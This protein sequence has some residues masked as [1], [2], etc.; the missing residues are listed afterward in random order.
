MIVERSHPA[1]AI[2]AP[3]APAMQINR[4]LRLAIAAVL[5]G[6]LLPGE[7]SALTLEQRGRA[8]V[9]KMC[10]ACHAVGRIGVSPH[11]GAPAFRVLDRRFDL[12]DFIVRLRNGLIATHPDMPMF[13][14]GDEDG[15]AVVA[16]LRSIQVR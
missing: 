13:R 11:A 7:A 16:Y 5:F 3:A 9:T 12:D 1:A 15:E 4:L 2:S 8:L 6:I 10:A 14:F